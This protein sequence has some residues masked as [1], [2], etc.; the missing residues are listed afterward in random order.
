MFEIISRILLKRFGTRATRIGK[1]YVE[2]ARP[3][4]QFEEQTKKLDDE[5]LKAK[6]AEFKAAIKD[7]LPENVPI[8][9]GGKPS[10]ALPYFGPSAQRVLGRM[11]LMSY[12][13]PSVVDER[14][15]NA[16]LGTD[17]S[18]TL[19]MP[20]SADLTDCLFAASRYP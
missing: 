18:T 5:T 1:A 4:E 19:F 9:L 6:T 3:A 2:A 15:I 10:Y 16:N 14:G 20:H 12:L 8:C 13:R 17:P 7:G 11:G